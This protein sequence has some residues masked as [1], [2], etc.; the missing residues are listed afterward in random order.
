MRP[1]RTGSLCVPIAAHGM[2]NAQAAVG[3][4][5]TPDLIE[6]VF[7]PVNQTEFGVICGFVFLVVIAGVWKLA[8]AAEFIPMPYSA[9][10]DATSEPDVSTT[11]ETVPANP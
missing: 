7:R 1:V 6:F 11:P 2:Y 5:G 3:G 8:S 4:L 10:V 9:N